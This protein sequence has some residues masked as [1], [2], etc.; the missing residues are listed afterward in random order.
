MSKPTSQSEH[1]QQAEIW[2]TDA[3]QALYAQLCNAFYARE[4]PRL[5]DEPDTARLKR[6]LASLPYY[7]ERLAM[8]IVS[9]D[10]PLQ[11]DSQNGSWLEK[12]KTTPPVYNKRDSKDFYSQHAKRGLIVPVLINDE[13]CTTVRIDS[14]DQVSDN[15]VHCN[16]L[17]WFDTSGESLENTHIQL[18]KP[19]KAVMAAACCGHQWQFNK[20][21]TPKR[22][23][24]R[25]M[26]LA[27]NINWRNLKRPL[28]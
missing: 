6:L 15:K 7:I 17:G 4:I 23:S 14:L 5:V 9:G 10:A 19:A 22:L 27:S 24:L 28:T 21:I 2:Q 3:E 13:Q 25:E 26:L 11:L 1:S 16:E 8:R 20:R 12:Q 18:L